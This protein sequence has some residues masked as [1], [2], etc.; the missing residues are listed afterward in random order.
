MP[1]RTYKEEEVG[2]QSTNRFVVPREIPTTVVTGAETKL[3]SVQPNLTGKRKLPY[4]PDDIPEEPDVGKVNSLGEWITAIGGGL[5]LGMWASEIGL[6]GKDAQMAS[7]SLLKSSAAS[8]NSLLGTQT[9]PLRDINRDESG[10]TPFQRRQARKRAVPV[11]RAVLVPEVVR[12]EKQRQQEKTLGFSQDVIDALNIKSG[13]QNEQDDNPN[14][15]D[16]MSVDTPS[17]TI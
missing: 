7:S 9:G 2:P 6:L 14:D 3:A 10:K 5:S 11:K 17:A 12:S 4:Q 15:V 13:T 8:I 16:N 1:S